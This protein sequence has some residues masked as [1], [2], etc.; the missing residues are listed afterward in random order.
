MTTA[1]TTKHQVA[2]FHCGQQV[3]SESYLC[4]E[5]TFCCAGCRAVYQILR[6]A[7]MGAYYTVEEKAGKK[8]TGQDHERFGYLDDPAITPRLLEFFD[9]SRSRVTFSVPQIHCSACVWLLE[10]LF[11]L[12]PGIRRST[13]D[14]LARR[15]TVEYN[16]N[17]V[18]LSEV[19]SLLA[20]LGY[21]PD[22]R[23]DRVDALPIR[24]PNLSLYV[25]I[26]VAGFSFANI[27]LF[28][29]PEYL[30]SGQVGEEGISTLFRY[31]N[32]LLSVPVLLYSA[33]DYFKTAYS[34]LRQKTVNLDFPIALGLTA[35]FFR[36][37]FDVLTGT[38]PGYFDSFTGLVFFLLV[39]KLFQRKTYQW[40]SFERDYRA[41]FPI[42]V[43]RKRGQVEET[44]TVT[45]VG[46]GD[47]LIIRNQELFPADGILMIGRASVDYSFVTGESEPHELQI[48][49]RV[50]AGGRQIGGAVEIE[51]IKSV[52]QS[53]LV[54]LWSERRDSDKN[55][56]L[57]PKRVLSSVTKG[58]GAYFTAAVLLIA[59]GTAIW[60][61]ETDPTRWVHA[62]TSVLLV[63]CPCAIALSAPFVFGSA[64]RLFGARQL[65]VRH[66]DVIDALSC[67]DTIVF[68]KTGTLTRADDKSIAF[69]GPVL[70]SGERVAVAAVARHSTHP[71]SR[72]IVDHIGLSET[73]P[74]TGFRETPGQGV[75]G[76]VY[77]AQIHLGR[78]EFVSASSDEDQATPLLQADNRHSVHLSIDGTYRGAF[79]LGSM[80]RVGLADALAEL[81]KTFELSV[82][83][84]DTPREERRL[85]ELLG[86]KASLVFN[87]LPHQKREY[88]EQLRSRGRRVLMLGDGLNDAGALASADVGIAVTEDTSAFAP[89]CDGILH[90]G[91]LE[92]LGRFLRSSRAARRVVYASF[93]ISV[94]YNIIGL[95]FAATG[96]LSPLVSAILMPV[97]SVSVVAFG[98]GAVWLALRR[99]GLA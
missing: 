73:P 50:Y 36:S 6:D 58:I 71:A 49:E 4:D 10:N 64:M 31:A 29:F 69:E 90:S 99:Q 23:L 62:F 24:N 30:S 34:G 95:S 53:Y 59:A 47:R 11:R 43:R 51:V 96:H 45:S 35:L 56:S 9:S 41:Y 28:S 3:D 27:M 19:V 48:G 54:S 39:G 89:A 37:G 70:S 21:E 97:S 8:P 86:E 5:K 84:G 40:L 18:K 15:L 94:A 88:V 76:I 80:Y 42:A 2:C 81:G 65:F 44:A 63:A 33:T 91:Q 77:G 55:S 79:K 87:Q 38:G 25:K 12:N 22:I 61:L 16:H 72:Q 82:L 85:R 92:R 75:V 93:A 74:V 13:V 83:T 20:R 98:T 1:S 66:P 68:D 17:A 78:R 14:F 7:D 60:W 26:G 46:V 57:L 52:D 32:L 67:I